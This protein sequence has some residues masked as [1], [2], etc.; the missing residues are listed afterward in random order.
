MAVLVNGLGFLHTQ[1]DTT[2]VDVG[3]VNEPVAAPH[4]LHHRGH[5]DDVPVDELAAQR[6]RLAGVAR[7]PDEAAHL[8]AILD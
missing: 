4:P 5:V 3:K 6:L 7:S 1:A 2:G 8:V